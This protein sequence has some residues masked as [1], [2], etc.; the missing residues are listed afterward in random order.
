MLYT[1][2][3]MAV[4]LWHRVATVMV[5]MR[6]TMLSGVE[7]YSFMLAQYITTEAAMPTTIMRPENLQQVRW[8][9]GTQT[10]GRATTSCCGK[11]AES[12]AG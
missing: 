3:T 11:A 4:T 9:R 10:L 6:P 5:I 7:A 1:E 12:Y 2:R 8:V